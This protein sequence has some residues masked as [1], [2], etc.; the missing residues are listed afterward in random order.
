MGLKSRE[1][2]PQ[3]KRILREFLESTLEKSGYQKI[4]WKNRARMRW[5]KLGH[6]NTKFFHTVATKN[7]RRNLITGTFDP[8]SGC[9]IVALFPSRPRYI[10]LGEAI[11]WC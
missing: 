3:L 5:A 2:C 6:E 1:T 11:P 10:K 8:V 4:I 9:R 7:Y